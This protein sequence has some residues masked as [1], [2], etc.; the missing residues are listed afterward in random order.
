MFRLFSTATKASLS[1]EYGKYGEGVDDQVERA[2]IGA[3]H[4]GGIREMS[5]A[6]LGGLWYAGCKKEPLSEQVRTR[7]AKILTDI[8]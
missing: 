4:V 7:S 2:Q 1:R 3:D 5:F 8:P 6:T